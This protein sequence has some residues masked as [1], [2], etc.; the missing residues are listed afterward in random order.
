MIT[1]D[2]DGNEKRFKI[3]LSYNQKL[4]LCPYLICVWVLELGVNTGN[5]YR[6][7]LLSNPGSGL[8]ILDGVGNEKCSVC[9]GIGWIVQLERLLCL[10]RSHCASCTELE[11]RVRHFCRSTQLRLGV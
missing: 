9:Y 5:P 8:G 3:L 4:I 11:S 10:R 6:I 7:R 2:I 1:G